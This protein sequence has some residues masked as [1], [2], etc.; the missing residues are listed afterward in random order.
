MAKSGRARSGRKAERS[1][2]G[3]A[4]RWIVGVSALGLAMIA[5]YVLMNEGAG[6]SR[7]AAEMQP[8]GPALDDIDAKSREAMRD[9]LRDAGD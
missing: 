2:G 7:A 8:S 5:F 1:S 3:G 9:L 4:V 6:N